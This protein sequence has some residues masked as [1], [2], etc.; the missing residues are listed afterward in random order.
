MKMKNLDIEMHNT[1]DITNMTQKEIEDAIHAVLS[2]EKTFAQVAAEKPAFDVG[3]IV[4]V[5]A[6]QGAS[7]RTRNRIRERGAQGFEVIK[8][9]QTASFADNRGVQWVL[10]DSKD[11]EWRGWLPVDE[12]EVVNASR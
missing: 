4:E 7:Q 12:L 1:L 6:V 8:R 9:P 10:L 2:G 11:S 3:S 5:K